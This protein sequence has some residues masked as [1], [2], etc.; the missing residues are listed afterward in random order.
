MKHQQKVILDNLAIYGNFGWNIFKNSNISFLEEVIIINKQDQTIL[1]K[2]N[3]D[4][5]SK[6]LI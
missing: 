4:Q 2:L 5:N 3:F 1:I 6:N